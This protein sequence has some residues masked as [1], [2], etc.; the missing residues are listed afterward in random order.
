MAWQEPRHTAAAQTRGKVEERLAGQVAEHQLT[1]CR[2]EQRHQRGSLRGQETRRPGGTDGVTAVE[3]STRTLMEVG[4]SIPTWMV[5]ERRMAVRLHMV[6][7][8]LPCSH[9]HVHTSTRHQPVL[10]HIQHDKANFPLT[11][12]PHGTP[13]P[14]PPTTP[15]PATPTLTAGPRLPPGHP[16]AP[17]AAPKPPP[18]P[19]TPTPLAAAPPPTPPPAHPPTPTRP[20]T[21]RPPLARLPPAPA[22]TLRRR[23]RTQHRRPEARV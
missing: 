14:Q 22:T 6:V 2:L 13:T 19:P 10:F 8:V 7:Y 23:V 21:T 5:V 11:Y 15:T 1:A 9:S 20:R 12:S 3:Q 17:P 4:Q 16:A 18:G